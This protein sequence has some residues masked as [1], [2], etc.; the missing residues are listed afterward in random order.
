MDRFVNAS[1]VVIGGGIVG[2]SI[3]YNLAARGVRDVV[4]LE[5]ATVGSGTTGRSVGG[6][7]LL[8]HDPLHAELAFRGWRLFQRLSEELDGPTDF[9]FAESLTLYTD[10][11]LFEQGLVSSARLRAWGIAL[12]V[13]PLNSIPRV[14]P[15][16]ELTGLVGAI[17]CPDYAKADPY[18]VTQLYRKAAERRGVHVRE[19][20]LVTEVL[21]DGGRVV[22]VKT[23]AEVVRAEVVVNAA[24]AEA[25]GIAAMSGV[26]LPL[27]VTKRQAFAL[28]APR[29]TG[30]VLVECPT[31]LNVIPD[32]GGAIVIQ[33]EASASE[34]GV[35]WDQL[36]AITLSLKRRVPVLS[37]AG[38]RRA[39]TG[40][41]TFSVDGRP[42]LG[43]AFDVLGFF[44]AVAWGG[45]GFALGP[46]VGAVAAEMIV[47]GR[48]TLDV[49][50]LSPSRFNRPELKSV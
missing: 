37:S 19:G 39:W 25:G 27:V 36:D 7:Y 3:A 9:R 2:C 29:F 14:A 17:H 48:A 16:V 5:K 44:C 4:L 47:D 28:D 33:G 49:S 31:D 12:E 50:Q 41:R 15:H 38:V 10:Q 22:G 42:I 1:V 23:G 6:I 45:M 40:L 46:S 35:D 34:P 11:A 24:G 30:P 32:A 18:C 13:L 8:E 21:R 20:T 26:S 43:F